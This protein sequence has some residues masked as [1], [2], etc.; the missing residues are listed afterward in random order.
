MVILA[1]P[2]TGKTYASMHLAGVVDVEFGRYFLPKSIPY[3]RKVKI[4]QQAVEKFEQK[5][6]RFVLAPVSLAE[7]FP[8]AP[9]F[10]VPREIAEKRLARRGNDEPTRR[11]MNDV[12]AQLA[13]LGKR[14][15][16]TSRYL[17]DILFEM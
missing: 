2:T 14:V 4:Y 7:I 10:A 9:I 3:S 15:E 8:Q 6:F 11:A 16:F 13:R 17:F 1:G 5:G 12:Y